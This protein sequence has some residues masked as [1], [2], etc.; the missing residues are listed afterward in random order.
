MAVTQDKRAPSLNVVERR[1]IKRYN[2]VADEIE[3]IADRIAKMVLGMYYS[4]IILV[5]TNLLFISTASEEALNRAQEAKASIDANLVK[6]ESTG[7]DE[8]DI[9]LLKRYVVL[10]LVVAHTNYFTESPLPRA[11]S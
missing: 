10:S 1:V 11:I 9:A 3:D 8:S 6:L 7:T 2:A 5:I 4:V